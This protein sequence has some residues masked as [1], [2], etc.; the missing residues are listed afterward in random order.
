MARERNNLYQIGMSLMNYENQQGAL[1]AATMPNDALPPEKRLSWLL[2]IH[3]YIEA[4]DIY[5]RFDKSKAWD[6]EG[7]GQ[8]S[9]IEIRYFSSPRFTDPAARGPYGLTQYVG[10]AGV[11]ADAATLPPGHPRAGVF[12][13][14]RQTKRTDI[15]DGTST[16]MMVIDTTHQNGPWAAGGPATVRGVDPEQRPY[17]GKGRPFGGRFER[18]ALVLF[19][20]GSVRFVSPGV[21]PEVFEAAATIA[22]GE[23]IDPNELDGPR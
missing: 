16:T 22:G 2:A 21:K 1:P 4:D 12:G 6:D 7:N 23:V 8:L 18:G 3:P 13:Y 9:A 14:Y 17:I 20:D 15:T 19:A 11:G 5:V 10:V